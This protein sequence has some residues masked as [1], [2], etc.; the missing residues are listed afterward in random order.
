MTVPEERQAMSGP[1]LAAKGIHEGMDG[2]KYHTLP[3]LSNTGLGKHLASPAHYRAYVRNPPK[4]TPALRLGK[5]L[6]KAVLEP[7]ALA[8]AIAPNVDRRTNSGKK[9]WADFLLENP[10]AEI[11]TADEA[12]QIQFMRDAVYSHPSARKLL[13][14]PGRAEASAWWYDDLEGVL[15]KC[16]PDYARD[17][18]IIVDLKSTEDAEPNAFGR[19][20]VKYGYVRQGAFYWDGWHRVTGIK[21][22]GFVFIAVEKEPPYAVSVSALTPIQLD[23]GRH[24]YRR[25]LARYSECQISGHWPGYSDKIE[26]LALPAWAMKGETL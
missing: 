20:A 15:C 1:A 24:E 8:L 7:D 18:H 23:M 16:R 13:F 22:E 25:A 3:G 19:S 21:P 9:A 4:E 6:H 10:G 12:D 17:D 26:P 14:A 5:L 2:D 11:V